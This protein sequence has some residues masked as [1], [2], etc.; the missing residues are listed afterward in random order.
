MKSFKEITEAAAGG[1]PTEI[2]KYNND[3]IYKPKASPNYDSLIHDAS[4][5]IDDIMTPG[6]YGHLKKEY[7]AIRITVYDKDHKKTLNKL[8]KEVK[9]YFAKYP[10]FGILSLS[11]TGLKNEDVTAERYDKRLFIGTAILYK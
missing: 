4:P 3:W 10:E 6:Q 11:T 9:K 1:M 7:E 5:A 8:N 2:I